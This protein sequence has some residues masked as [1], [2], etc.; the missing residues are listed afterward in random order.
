MLLQS[1]S[2]P[3]GQGDGGPRPGGGAARGGA[4]GIENYSTIENVKKKNGDGDG[5][6]K[7]FLFSSVR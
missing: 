5:K 4:E 7:H 2:G 1:A 6:K 3:A